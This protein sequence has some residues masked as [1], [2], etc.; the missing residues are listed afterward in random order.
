MKLKKRKKKTASSKKHPIEKDLVS[1]M[2]TEIERFRDKGE[3]VEKL[4]PR[5]FEAVKGS[6]LKTRRRIKR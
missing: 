2:S 5:S 3:D 4:L 1:K 6:H